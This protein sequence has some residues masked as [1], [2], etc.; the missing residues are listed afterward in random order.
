MGWGPFIPALSLWDRGSPPAWY[1]VC[2]VGVVEALHPRTGD[3]GST[4]HPNAGSV[5]LGGA[6]A[7]H[8]AVRS[9]GRGPLTPTLALWGRGD[10]GPPD[11]SV[12]SIGK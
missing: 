4:P 12:G 11:G 10:T 8:G 6:G 7:P 1:R 5:G 2:G 3:M 9:M